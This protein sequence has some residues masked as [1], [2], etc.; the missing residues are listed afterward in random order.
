MS[1]MAI[2]PISY[3]RQDICSEDIQEVVKV[4]K[5]DYLTQG[6]AVSTFEQAVCRKVG[7]EHSVAVNSATSALHI[8]CLAL[9]VGKGDVVWTTP[10][11][12]V[13]SANAALYC[14]A[15]VDFVD[16][17]P[18]TYNMCPEKLK[19]KLLI[20]RD[21]GQ[22]PKVVIP[23]HFAGRGCDMLAI[24]NLSIEFGFKIIEDASHAL[25]STYNGNAIGSCHY[26]DLCVFSFHP[27]KMI[28]TGEGGLVTT[29]S[30]ETHKK[31]VKL[32]EH[33]ITKSINDNELF[34][35]SGEIWFGRQSTLG[36]N[37]RMTDIQAALGN[38]QLERLDEFLSTRQAIVKR[39]NTFFSNLPITTPH[40]PSDDICSFHLYVILLPDNGD[41]TT[42]A[43]FFRHLR[44]C[45]INCSVHYIPV[46]KHP[47]YENLGFSS[48]YCPV[49]ENYFH[50]AISLPIFTS[51]EEQRQQEVI[52][53]VNEFFK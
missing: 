26:S 45:G 13:A 30:V 35:P 29:N 28:T 34:D 42:Q 51:L 43:T 9:G 3:G 23:V 31:L 1:K 36:F 6:P 20:C 18:V 5:S 19:S 10:N 7:A 47:F 44:S 22:L 14:G 16:I 39:Y 2:N 33:G 17:D 21:R 8:S 52:N 41:R 46:Y 24:K 50:R 32:R 12:F 27:V 25:G 15:T 40:Q 11:T 4:L 48:G 53:A 49:C 38:S 37:Y